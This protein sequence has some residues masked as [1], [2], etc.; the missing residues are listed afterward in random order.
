MAI[1]RPSLDRLENFHVVSLFLTL[2]LMFSSAAV[3][4]LDFM[5]SGAD[6]V[7]LGINI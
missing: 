2:I 3:Y 5:L 7:A 1:K 6:Y 4:V